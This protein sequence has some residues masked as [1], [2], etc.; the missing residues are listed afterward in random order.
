MNDTN[1]NHSER[2][3]DIEPETTPMEAVSEDAGN[4]ATQ[5][6]QSVSSEGSTYDSTRTRAEQKIEY[7]RRHAAWKQ[8]QRA[9]RMYAREARQNGYPGNEYPGASYAAPS[10]GTPPQP[11]Y[12]RGPNVGAIVWGCITLIVGVVVMLWLLLPTIFL[13][14]NIWAIILSIGFAAIGL[15]LVIGAIVTSISGA[16]RKKDDES[17]GPGADEPAASSENLR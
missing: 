16:L 5:P 12:K 2:G 1:T 8:Q 6:M 3:A 17:F 15:S 9:S 11:M 7:K 13:A 10:A 14:A 4:D